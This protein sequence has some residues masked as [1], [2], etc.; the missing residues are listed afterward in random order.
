MTL[1]GTRLGQYG[2]IVLYR[3][4]P[5]LRLATHVGGIYPDSWMGDFAALTHYTV[6]WR[7]GRI[8]VDVSRTGWAAPS[9]PGTVTINIGPLGN[10]NGEPG[11]TTVTASRTWTVRSGLTRSFV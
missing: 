1:H 2:R 7:R 6:P 4:S 8:R 5:P 11:I 9:P 3:T 10:V